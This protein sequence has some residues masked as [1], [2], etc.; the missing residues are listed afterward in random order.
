MAKR[1]MAF[2]PFNSVEKLKRRHWML[3]SRWRTFVMDWVAIDMP[4]CTPFPPST[5]GAEA[6]GKVPSQL[7]ASKVV[8]GLPR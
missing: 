3:P 8:R 7:Y 6:Y 4:L 1:L 2:P 5:A